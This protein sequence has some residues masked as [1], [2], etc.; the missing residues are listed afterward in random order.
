MI[1]VYTGNGK[2]KT[3]AALGLAI[4]AAG[5][6]LKI[7]I[8]QFLKRNDSSELNS[9]KKISNIKVEQFGSKCFIKSEPTKK[10]RK[11]AKKGLIKVKEILTRKLFDVVILDEINVAL[12]LKL[13]SQKEVIELINNVPKKTELVLTGC[14]APGKIKKIADLVSE[15]K[16]VKHYYKSGIKA[17]RGIEY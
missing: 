15:I 12:N 14:N 10:D 8:G 11:L 17:R 6:G 5:A 2:G 4:R 13:I 1:Q 16:E 3:S 7:Y 9:L